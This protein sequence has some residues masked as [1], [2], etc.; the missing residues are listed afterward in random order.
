VIET[1]VARPEPPFTW[2]DVTDPTRE[3]LL[4][5]ARRHGLHPA[6]VQDCLDPVHL[7]KHE[8]L[9]SQKFVIVR[10]YDEATDSE[11]ASTQSLTRK[12]AIFASGPLVLT[13]HR[14]PQAYLDRAKRELPE[15]LPAEEAPSALV[16][17]LVTAALDTFRAP[18]DAAEEAVARH[19]ESVF[20]KHDVK[21]VIRQV[22]LLKRR[23]TVIRWVV[24]HTRDVLLR[25]EPSGRSAPLQVDARETADSVYFGADELIEDID[26]LINIQ[27]S[28]SAHETNEVIRVLTIFSAFFMPL[29]FLVGV[30]GMN[31]V[32][33]PELKWRYG[34][35][36]AWAAMAAT[37]A[38]IWVGFR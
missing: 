37:C 28:L 31:F 33:M 22:Y 6:W 21:N 23:V 12:L 4:D 11:A 25:L 32:H 17:L 36:L 29:T 19:E 5:L 8:T 3:E 10:S 30:Y 16:P 38:G 15:K 9:G 20:G 13:I 26:G 18:I 2:I 1:V 24:R 35:A 34:Y 27:L 14:K 7:P